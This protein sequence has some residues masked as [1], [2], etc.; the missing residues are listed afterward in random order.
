MRK[1]ILRRL[2]TLGR[3]RL[4][5]TGA[6]D[7]IPARRSENRGDVQ[8]QTASETRRPSIGRRG[9]ERSAL[10]GGN[11]QR[12]QNRGRNLLFG[13]HRQPRGTRRH[14]HER[15]KVLFHRKQ[16]P[17]RLSRRNRGTA[18]L[19]NLA[20]RRIRFLRLSFQ[21]TMSATATMSAT[22]LATAR[23]PLVSTVAVLCFFSVPGGI[24]AAFAAPT[25]KP[26]STAGCQWENLSIS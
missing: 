1:E 21:K 12:P 2:R 26:A 5:N 14:R 15:P 13:H 3:P 6:L 4:R 22:V 7:Q 17:Y 19:E 24:S 18:L 16:R 10:T 8:T 9:T 20:R 11:P 23:V 25:E